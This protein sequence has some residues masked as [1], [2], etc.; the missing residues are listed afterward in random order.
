MCLPCITWWISAELANYLEIKNAG[1]G[2]LL[3]FDFRKE[4]SSERKEEWIKIGEKD[5]F[6]VMV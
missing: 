6:S 3:T 4:V 2:Y 1:K 5:V